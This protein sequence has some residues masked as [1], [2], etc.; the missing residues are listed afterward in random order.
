[1]PRTT[2]AA[3]GRAEARG[4]AELLRAVRAGHGPSFD[5]IR[6]RHHEAVFAYALTCAWSAQVAADL[7][8]AA[9]AQLRDRVASPVPL[10]QGRHSGCV[11]LQLLESVRLGAVTR[12]LRSPQSFHREFTDW[13][14]GGSMWPM[15][16]DGQLALAFEQLP[17]MAQ[18][19][20]WHAL[21][22]AD[23]ERDIAAVTGL[24]GEDLTLALQQA[25]R[26]LRRSRTDLYCERLENA[27]CLDILAG[28]PDFP[29]AP[30][31]AAV[32][33]HLKAC[34]R[35]LALHDDLVG[36]EARAARHL[37]LRLLGWW[38][39]Q[40]YQRTK[41]EFRSPAF[42]SFEGTRGTAAPA[43][44]PAAP[45]GARHRKT[46]TPGQVTAL[47]NR[48]GK[49]ALAVA[50]VLL[51][52]VPAVHRVTTEGPGSPSADRPA[53]EP[54]VLSSGGVPADSFA[55]ARGTVRPRSGDPRARP[56]AEGSELLY[57]QVDFGTRASA[58]LQVLVSDVTE[59][60]RRLELRIGDGAD[61]RS[62]ATVELPPGTGEKWVGVRVEPLTGRHDVRVIGRCAGQDPCVNLHAFRVKTG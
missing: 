14:R 3:R 8:A 51:A 34:P 50:A 46:R 33:E 5:V 41:D 26:A 30:L 22:E 23:D 11:R 32:V 43:A 20:L 2:F 61:G 21:V 60:A 12:A 16:E 13:I 31:D 36:L 1:M 29:A 38:P 9:F 54:L 44:R 6:R 47:R 57:S 37:P 48:K 18:C 53:A 45:S 24:S 19:L 59:R 35:C 40:E 49:A 62:W 58:R 55:H 52:A 28:A 25:D 17:A 39:I 10:D 4:D 56:L 7:A 27:D 42:D 15:L